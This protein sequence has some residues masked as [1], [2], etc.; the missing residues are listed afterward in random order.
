MR[1]QS[2]EPQSPSELIESE[3]R[4][5]SG[6]CNL[7]ACF[8]QFWGA[9]LAPQPPSL[10]DCR[11][12][13]LADPAVSSGAHKVHT[14][15]PSAGTPLC[16][17]APG[18]WPRQPAPGLQTQVPFLQPRSMVMTANKQNPG[19]MTAVPAVSGSRPPD[20]AWPLPASVPQDPC[21]QRL[22]KSLE[23]L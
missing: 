9:L 23:S 18:A 8:L 7:V 6:V 17:S 5:G 4:K 16:F 10:R 12:L 13:C 19:N 15:T 11:L 1:V 2:V 20:S 3:T 22:F 21:F 14:G